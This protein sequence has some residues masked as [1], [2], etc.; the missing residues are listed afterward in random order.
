M[1][2][3]S[4]FFGARVSIDVLNSVDEVELREEIINHL[5]C[6]LSPSG[7]AHGLPSLIYL[8]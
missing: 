3:F 4:F 6:V 5:T 2:R 7:L 8:A 1:S